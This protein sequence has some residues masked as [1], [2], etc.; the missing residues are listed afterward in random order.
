MPGG[1]SQLTWRCLLKTT[2]DPSVHSRGAHTRVTA[3]SPTT[4]P[5]E[6]RSSPLS[7]DV[8]PEWDRLAMLE[9][10]PDSNVKI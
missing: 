4:C 8:A 10:V 2:H 9:K 7:P 1:G 5:G 3:P 6:G